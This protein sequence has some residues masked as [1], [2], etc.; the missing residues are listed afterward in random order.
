MKL[1]LV[2]EENPDRLLALEPLLRDRYR[3]LFRRSMAEGMLTLDVVQPHLILLDVTTRPGDAVEFL[4]TIR[5]RPVY[6]ATPVIGMGENSAE[7]DIRP[8]LYAGFQ[9]VVQRPTAEPFPL[10][11]A[12][13]RFLSSGELGDGAAGNARMVAGDV[14]P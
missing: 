8:F 5:R 9:A 6:R 7:A 4:R 13:D 14:S 1:L 2:V 3:P 11:R 12:I 10:F